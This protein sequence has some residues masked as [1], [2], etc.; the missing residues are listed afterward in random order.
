MIR[1]AALL[2]APVLFTAACQPASTGETDGP[3][4]SYTDAYI[5]EPLGGRDVTAGGIKI[6]VE[7]GDVRLTGAITDVA[8]TVETHTMAMDGDRMTM[9]PVDGWDIKDGETLELKRGGN[10]LMLFGVIDGLAAGDT[11]NIS[12][13]FETP[14]GETLTLEAET[15]VR[16]LGE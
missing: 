3:V 4:L 8:A 5:M 9:S 14:E 16:A 7:G 12:F 6:S 11:A 2:F 10:H 1:A 15:D 13:T